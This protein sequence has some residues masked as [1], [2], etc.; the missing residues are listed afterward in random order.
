MTGASFKSAL[1]LFYFVVLVFATVDTASPGRYS[2]E[3]STYL[4][5]VQYGILLLLAAD[6]F[7]GQIFKDIESDKKL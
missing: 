7:I 1:Y 5:S 6:T 3:F 2:D 4:Q